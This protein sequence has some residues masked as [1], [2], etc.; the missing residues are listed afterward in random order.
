[1]LEQLAIYIKNE[2]RHR[3]CTHH[4]NLELTW[5]LHVKH[6]TIELLG[7]NIRENL[8]DLGFDNNFLDTLKAWSMKERIHEQDFIKIK[9][10]CSAKGTVKMM[11]KKATDYKK[12]YK[13]PT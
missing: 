10:F 11:N 1:M 12:N 5:D 7:D 9:I 2:L 4:K 3:P 8:D 6:K 13:K